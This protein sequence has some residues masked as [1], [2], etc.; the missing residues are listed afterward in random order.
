MMN[1]RPDMPLSMPLIV[2]AVALGVACPAPAGAQILTKEPEAGQLAC[3]QKVL[4]ENNTCPPDQI[5]EVTGSCIKTTVAI[6][7]ARAP[8]GTQYNCIKRKRD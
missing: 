8:R 1:A 7:I 4:V 3:G 5:L 6:D 2:V